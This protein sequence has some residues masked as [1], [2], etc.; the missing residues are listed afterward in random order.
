MPKWDKTAIFMPV[1]PRTGLAQT[2]PKLGCNLNFYGF[3]PH[4]ILTL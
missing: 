4:K 2:L 1:D 3:L